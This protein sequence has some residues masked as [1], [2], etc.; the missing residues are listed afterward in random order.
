MLPSPYSTPARD[1]TLPRI[2]GLGQPYI[3]TTCKGMRSMRT[4]GNRR[5]GKSLR[6]SP[7]RRWRGGPE[8]ED[9]FDTRNPAPARRLRFDN[10][11]GRVA[12]GQAWQRGHRAPAEKAGLRD[13]FQPAVRGRSELFRTA[14]RN[15]AG[16]GRDKSARPVE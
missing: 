6:A 15:D 13:I 4:R 11:P 3:I 8:T 14:D 5:Q 16:S 9:E 12:C 2:R 1:R 10:W 7:M